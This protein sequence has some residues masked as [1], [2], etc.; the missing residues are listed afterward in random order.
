MILLFCVIYNLYNQDVIEGR[1]GRRGKRG[2]R[3]KTGK[4]G[5]RGGKRG[6]TGRDGNDGRDGKD[7]KD[8]KTGKRGPTYV[9]ND[10]LSD[11]DRTLDYAN[12]NK[13]GI[14]NITDIIG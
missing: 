8:G 1:R 12:D 5:K 13:R 14:N 6:K 3:G 2:K 11:I 9:L 4:R 7:G 10:V